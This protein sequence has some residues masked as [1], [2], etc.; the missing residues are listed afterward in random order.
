MRLRFLS[1]KDYPRL[2]G[3]ARCIHKGRYKTKTGGSKSERFEADTLP[4][5]GMKEGAAWGW[6]WKKHT[7]RNAGD[8]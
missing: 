6:G 5:L 2:S 7:P 8:L 3:R 4:A 1:W